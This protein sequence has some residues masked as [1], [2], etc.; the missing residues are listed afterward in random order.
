V[1]VRRTLLRLGSE[2]M[3]LRERFGDAVL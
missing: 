3:R 1:K 2:P